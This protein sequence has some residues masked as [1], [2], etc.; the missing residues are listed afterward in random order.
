[1]ATYSNE[2][3]LNMDMLDLMKLNEQELEQAYNVLQAEANRRLQELEDEG[4]ALSS[5]AYRSISKELGKNKQGNPR[6]RKGKNLKFYQ[7]RSR[8]VQLR[9]FLDKKTSSVKGVYEHYDKIRKKSGA[10]LNMRQSKEFFDLWSEAVAIDESIQYPS[11]NVL[12]AQDYYST[13]FTMSAQ[14]LVDFI[15]KRRKKTYEESRE[16]DELEKV[17]KELYED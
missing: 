12:K 7:L 14:D 16:I 8:V 1:M 2:Q 3:I 4:I 9:Q 11:D 5:Y 13:D 15:N 10:N 6:F 17:F